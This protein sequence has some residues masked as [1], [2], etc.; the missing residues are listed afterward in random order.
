MHELRGTQLWTTTIFRGFRVISKKG[1]IQV[2]ET[3]SKAKQ[4]VFFLIYF[5][6][7]TIRN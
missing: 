5:R 6:I 7:E 3:L 1:N 2:K 4:L